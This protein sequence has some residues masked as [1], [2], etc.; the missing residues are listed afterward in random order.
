MPKVNHRLIHALTLCSNLSEKLM[1]LVNFCACHGYP[2]FNLS[3]AGTL[4]P[5]STFLKVV[6]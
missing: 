3:I 5:Y 4:I 1:Y 2:I 6:E